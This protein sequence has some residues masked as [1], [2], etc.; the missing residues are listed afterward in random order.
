MTPKRRGGG[1]I[2]WPTSRRQ[3]PIG[4]CREQAPEPVNV[5]REWVN[6][7]V[8]PG[9]GSEQHR[10]KEDMRCTHSG[11]NKSHRLIPQHLEIMLKYK[12][13]CLLEL[14]LSTEDTKHFFS[15]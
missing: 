3:Q 12:P 2:D 1:T 6:P 5:W 13:C 7:L 8:T 15:R 10:I 4:S 9:S 14:H 11:A